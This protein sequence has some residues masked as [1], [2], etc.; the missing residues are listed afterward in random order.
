MYLSSL[1]SLRAF[2]GYVIQLYLTT[3]HPEMVVVALV[4][5]NGDELNALP[6][7]LARCPSKNCLPFQFFLLSC[8][9]LAAPMSVLSRLMEEVGRGGEIKKEGKEELKEKR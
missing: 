8:G 5:K 7:I 9:R 2:R 1:V 6:H 4:T 3:D